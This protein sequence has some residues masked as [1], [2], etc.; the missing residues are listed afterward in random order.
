[1]ASLIKYM[2]GIVLFLVMNVM[3]ANSTDPNKEIAVLLEDLSV[4][5]QIVQMFYRTENNSLYQRLN[6]LSQDL[7]AGTLHRVSHNF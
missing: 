2:A 5:L 7:K 6:K 4:E 1:M 3:T